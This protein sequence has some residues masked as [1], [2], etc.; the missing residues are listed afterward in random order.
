MSGYKGETQRG[1]SEGGFGERCGLW[2][3][4]S[5]SGLDARQRHGSSQLCRFRDAC[6]GEGSLDDDVVRS[7]WK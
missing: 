1:G 5:I 4:Y 7:R 6:G 2:L 3:A